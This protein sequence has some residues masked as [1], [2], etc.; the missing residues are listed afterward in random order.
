M[1]IKSMRDENGGNP[2][3][4][5]PLAL[6]ALV[7]YS[8]TLVHFVRTALSDRT[9]DG[10][11]GALARMIIEAGVTTALVMGVVLYRRR[12]ERRAAG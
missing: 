11:I 9:V 10:L 5:I 2:T 1:K 8:Q 6:V 12:R 4:R 3:H 7:L